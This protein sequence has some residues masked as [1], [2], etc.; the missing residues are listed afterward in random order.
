MRKVYHKA[1]RDS[2]RFLP[3]GRSVV[4]VMPRSVEEQ[5][6]HVAVSSGGISSEIIYRPLLKLIEAEKVR[7]DVLELG[8][9]LGL[10]TPRLAPYSA[11]LTAVDLLARPEGLAEAIRWVQADMNEPLPFPAGSFDAIL[12]VEVMGCLEN[13]RAAYR[14]YYRLLRPGG[15]LIV[16]MPNQRSIRSLFCII[17][18]GQFASF[19][20]P[21]YPGHITPL[22]HLD[23]QRICAEAGFAPPRFFY[24]DSGGL[25][26]FP[27]MTWQKLLFGLPR[28]KLFS[29][30]L[31]VVTRKPAA[32]EG[33]EYEPPPPAAG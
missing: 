9:G 30:N 11:Q 18:G 10:L 23:H 28:G 33:G 8:A 2:L 16:A 7:G 19:L 1:L 4:P 15:L 29:D 17:F 31:Q 14:D 26:K 5:R 24:T 32:A 6:L 22:Q 13:P 3:L 12:S 20:G 21:S 27:R 25:P